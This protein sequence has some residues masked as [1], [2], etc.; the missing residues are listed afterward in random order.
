MPPRPSASRDLPGRR[1]LR[2]PAI[3]PAPAT[4]EPSPRRPVI[5]ELVGGDGHGTHLERFERLGLDVLEIP[6]PGHP[7]GEKGLVVRAQWSGTKRAT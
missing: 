6:A 5:A 3:V 4:S 2:L 7:D 1:L